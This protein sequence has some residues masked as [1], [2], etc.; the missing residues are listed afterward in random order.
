MFSFC[1]ALCDFC[2][3]FCVPDL[4]LLRTLIFF[5][6]SILLLRTGFQL[7]GENKKNDFYYRNGFLRNGYSFCYRMFCFFFSVETDLL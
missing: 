3:F 2:N 5:I 6:L 4:C 1:A 7:W